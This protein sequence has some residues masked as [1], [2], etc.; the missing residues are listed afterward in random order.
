MAGADATVVFHASAARR[1]RP[2]QAGIAATLAEPA[3]THVVE[4]DDPARPTGR[5]RLARRVGRLRHHPLRPQPGEVTPE[6][7]RAW[8]GRPAPPAE[9]GLA[10]EFRGAVVDV[11]SQ[12][13]TGGRAFGLAAAVLILLVAFGSVVAMGLPIGTA[14]VG[15]CWSGCRASPWS[16]RWWTSPPSRRSWP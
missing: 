12:P 6:A 7:F 13:E 4:V 5:R 2:R 9:A 15:S 1:P 3:P 14:L 10:V 8:T 16:A 11:A